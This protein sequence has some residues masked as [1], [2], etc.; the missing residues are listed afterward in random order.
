[1]IATLST[2]LSAPDALYQAYERQDAHTTGSRMVRHKPHS[3]HVDITRMAR[4]IR[5]KRI[6]YMESLA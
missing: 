4:T 2:I 3:D 1:M 6:D 5:I